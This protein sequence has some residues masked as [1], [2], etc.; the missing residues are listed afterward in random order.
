VKIEVKSLE[1]GPAKALGE[2]SLSVIMPAHN[3][4]RTIGAAVEDIL[5]LD[6]PFPIELIVVDDGSTDRTA[7]ELRRF[8]PNHVTVFRHPAKRGKG[9]AVMSGV[10]LASGTHMVVFDADREYLASDLSRMFE[11]I[12]LGK[13][14]IVYG[15]RMFGMN[16]V[17][18][19]YRYAFGNRMMTL[20]ANILNDSCLTDLHT[21]LKMMPVALFREL[22]LTETGFGLDSEITAEILRRGYRPFE[23]PVTYVGRSHVEGKK[24]TWRDGVECIRV[25]GRV[26]LRGNVATTVIDLRPNRPMLHLEEDMDGYLLAGDAANSSI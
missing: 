13:T 17:Y 20:A 22:H 2:L 14:H 5:T 26:R 1:Q 8:N 11:P 7:R 15:T 19:S 16:T 24:V 10:A 4:E 18:H 9:A 12:M 3:E 23:V 21:C 25:L 6:A